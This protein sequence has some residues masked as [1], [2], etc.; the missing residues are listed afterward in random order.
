MAVTIRYFAS[1]RERL[2]RSEDRLDLATPA[3]ARDVWM[4]VAGGE[5][6]PA[7]VLVAINQ[8]FAKPEDL[9]RDGDE[10]AF[11]PPITGG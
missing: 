9:V 8:E 7:Q 11:F 10:L 1:L 3:S 2:G 4:Q 5:P 6:L